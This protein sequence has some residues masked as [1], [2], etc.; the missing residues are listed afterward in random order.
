MAGDPGSWNRYAYVGGDPVNR[1]DP[2]GLCSQDIDYNWWDD[3]QVPEG[4]FSGVMYPGNCTDSPVW[5]SW[6]NSMAPGSVSLNG[7]PYYPGGGGD[8]SGGEDYSESTGIPGAGGG[9]S[10]LNIATELW[11][12]YETDLAALTKPKCADL[13]GAK[14]GVNPAVLL[15]DLYRGI[16]NRGSIT[17][18][19][20]PPEYPGQVINATTSG[21]VVNGV[22]WATIEIND[23]A[24]VFVNG[25]SSFPATPQNQ[26]ITLLHELGHAVWNIFGDGSTKIKKDGGK[27]PGPS[28]DNTWQVKTKCF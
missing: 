17:I 12:A 2:K 15:A 5:V 18:G 27:N 19:D 23:L 9:G 10:L 25:T 16:G 22:N 24:G 7:S 13:F 21:S 14:S 20:I 11:V 6:A 4:D 8:S 3:D 1:K 28:L 26:A